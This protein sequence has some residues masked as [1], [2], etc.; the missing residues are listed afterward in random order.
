MAESSES[1]AIESVLSLTGEEM[2]K[3]KFVHNNMVPFFGAKIKGSSRAIEP[4]ESTLDH[5]QGAGSQLRSKSEQA[6]LFAPEA[7]MNFIAGAPN[8]NDFYQSRVVPGARAANTKP[9]EEIQVSLDWS[10]FL[11]LGSGGFNSGNEVRI[12]GSQRQ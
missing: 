7:N 6:P 4:E 10:G 12:C 9:W 1:K 3:H 5:M 11:M 8:N 2:E